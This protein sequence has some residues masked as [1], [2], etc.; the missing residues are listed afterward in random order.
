MA[1]V[2]TIGFLDDE[3][4]ELVKHPKI[5]AILEE[6]ANERYPH[7]RH[8]ALRCLQAGVSL[9]SEIMKLNKSAQQANGADAEPGSLANQE[10]SIN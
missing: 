7:Q 3:L 6:L 8:I 4:I 10:E 9:C 1:S 2:A 5:K